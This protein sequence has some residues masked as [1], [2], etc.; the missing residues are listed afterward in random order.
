MNTGENAEALRK[1]IDLT[2]K[3]SIILLCLHYYVFFYAAFEQWHLTY[4]IVKQILLNLG[5]T[6]LFSHFDIT[7]GA[8]LGMLLISLAGARGKKEEKL[9]LERPLGIWLVAWRYTAPA[10]LSWI[11]RRASW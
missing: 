4:T 2:R 7:K 6:G 5:R 9:A 3:C 8:A 1:I 11:S 10:S